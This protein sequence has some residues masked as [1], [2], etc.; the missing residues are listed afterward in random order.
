MSVYFEYPAQLASSEGSSTSNIVCTAFSHGDQAVCAIGT[1]DG[2]VQFFLEEGDRVEHIDSATNTSVPLDLQRNGSAT[3]LAWHPRLHI[4][5]TGWDDGTIALWSEKDKNSLREETLAHKAS[6]TLLQFSPEGT[7]LISGDSAGVLVV[8]NID[9]R[10]KLTQL[11]SY[12]KKGTITQ[13]VFR[14]PATLAPS[15]D[16]SPTPCPSFFFAGSAGKQPVQA[17]VIHPPNAHRANNTIYSTCCMMSGYVTSSYFIPL[18]V[19]ASLMLGVVDHWSGQFC[20][21]VVVLLFSLFSFSC[22]F[23]PCLFW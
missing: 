13:L 22:L 6:I 3:T 7:R 18:F 21:T 15:L 11:H 5:A 1:A 20:S 9:H 2:H 4:L 17:R 12:T 23:R 16:G 10:G 14:A 8:W 19:L